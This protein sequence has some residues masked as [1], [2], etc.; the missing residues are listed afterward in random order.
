MTVAVKLAPPKRV[1]RTRM[2]IIGAATRLF[3][4]RPPDAVT[5]DDITRE[6]DVAKGSFYTHFADKTALLAAMIDDIRAEIEP[7]VAVANRRVADPAARV[8]RGI[9]VYVRFALHAPER[10]TVLA[11]GAGGHALASDALNHGVVADLRSGLAQS[12]FAFDDVAVAV[13]LIEAVVRHLMLHIGRNADHSAAITTSHQACV[14]LL[15]GLGVPN[16]DASTI[17][18]AAMADMIG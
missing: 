9:A 14:M 5:I 6:A 18:Q 3:A 17:A 16:T 1:V 13:L 15:T 11:A 2:A 10:V 4:K 7:L 12:R 8:A